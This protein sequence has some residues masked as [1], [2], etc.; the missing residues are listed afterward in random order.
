MD[1]D[2]DFVVVW[3]SSGSYGSDNSGYSV[4]GQRYNADGLAQGGQFQVNSYT[5]D[6]QGVADV[7]M[8]SDGDF[9]VVW[10]SDSVTNYN[11][12]QGQRYNSAGTAQG[13]EFQVDSYTAGSPVY[14]EVAMDS[15]GDFVVVWHSWGSGGNDNDGSSVQGQRYDSA[16]MAQGNQF[17]VNSYTTDSQIWVAAAM[18]DE[19]DFVVVWASEGS[20]GNDTSSDSIQG[21]RYNS[22]GTA[23]GGE[24]QVNSYTTE[25]QRNVAVGMDGDGDFVVS[26][27]SKGSNYGDTSHYSVQGQRF[28]AVGTVEGS[29]FQVNQY[30]TNRQWLSAVA[31]DG[32]GNFAIAWICMSSYG[33]DTDDFSIQGRVFA[34]DNATPTPTATPPAT[35]TDTPTATA[36]P[37]L[38]VTPTHTPSPSATPGPTAEPTDTPTLTPTSSPVGHTVYLPAVV[39]D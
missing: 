28:N 16:G 6:N 11:S 17:Q 26:W 4:Q 32:D 9:V 34:T 8:D 31:M 37:T 10:M 21:Q 12:I 7:A 35:P 23:Q 18:D 39:A 1:S 33:R 19:G 14:P 29:Q 27:T 5:T 36:T 20:Y 38:T 2:G 3:E 13:S 25:I 15:D 30:T 24:F 22:V